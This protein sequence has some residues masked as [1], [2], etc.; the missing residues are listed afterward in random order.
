MLGAMLGDIVGSPFEFD[1]GEKI[2]D[3]GPLFSCE[4]IYTDDSVMTIA[5]AEGIMNAGLTASDDDIKREVVKSMK[6]WGARYPHAGYG[7]RFVWWLQLDDDKPYGS[8]GNGSA[9]RVSSVGWFYD[10]LERTRKVARLTAEVTHNHPEGIKGAEATASAIFMARTGKSKDE[11]KKYIIDEFGYDLS[12]TL[13]EI[14]PTYHHDESCQKT[15]PE[16][17]TAFLEGED[18]EDV[19]R[20]AVSLGGDCDT[21]TCIASGIAEAFYG[22]PEEYK[23]EALNRIAYDM[24]A[25]YERFLENLK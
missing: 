20:C 18:F 6:D 9:M 16:A 17:I 12:R 5:V 23:A 25:V 21:L 22:I 3:F 8:Y 15:V 2:K 1:R 10:S 14:R 7:G 19:V 4:S 11:I 24:R 13:D